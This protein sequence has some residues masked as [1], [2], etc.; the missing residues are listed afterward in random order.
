[1]KTR[2]YKKINVLLLTL[3]IACTGCKGENAELTTKEI[4]EEATISSDANS[5][6]N[7]SYVKDS[8][9]LFFNE[10]EDYKNYLSELAPS[11]DLLYDT[12]NH[13]N[14][15]D[16]KYKEV[17]TSIVDLFKKYNIAPEN[18]A[19]FYEN[20]RKLRV[21]TN[22]RIDKSE[23][24]G[25]AAFFESDA[26]EPSINIDE[27][28]V[29]FYT[30]LHEVIH[31][32]KEAQVRFGDKIIVIT[33][34]GINK[35]IIDEKNGIS[36]IE[37]YGLSFT[38]G[39]AEV[40][41]QRLYN[42]SKRL[43][44]AKY[45]YNISNSIIDFLMDTLDINLNSI[46]GYSIKD[47]ENAL[48]NIGIAEEDVRKI[49]LHMDILHT[50]GEDVETKDAARQ[51]FYA[52]YIPKLTK[53]Y[54]DL[55]LSTDMI[56]SKIGN[57]LKTSVIEKILD[58]N[59]IVYLGQYLQDQKSLFDEIDYLISET[60]TEH[61]MQPSSIYY[62]IGHEFEIYYELYGEASLTNGNYYLSHNWDETASNNAQILLYTENEE[63]KMC[64]YN[65]NVDG[66]LT[67][68]DYYGKIENIEN[69]MSLSALLSINAIKIENGYIKY[70]YPVEDMIKLL[71]DHKIT[72][73]FDQESFSLASDRYL[74]IQGS[75]GKII[76]VTSNQDGE[77]I[78]YQIFSSKMN[79]LPENVRIIAPLPELYEAEVIT[80]DNEYNINIKGDALNKYLTDKDKVKGKSYSLK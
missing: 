34:M 38:E 15:I 20:L 76:N 35:E 8:N 36:R 80:L 6:D 12:I 56:Y 66:S 37:Q 53:Y 70:T 10:Y 5:N 13:N 79:I 22:F 64:S 47:F 27:S 74:T 67:C 78:P 33:S 49:V 51:I 48:M 29:D 3:V 50:K 18:L 45:S 2:N 17:L 9:F 46:F 58:D 23:S 61:G 14:K 25:V 57:S 68:Y 54:L 24:T 71:K 16:G 65:E 32:C 7:I 63:I 11:Y 55:G 44:L 72:S 60:L 77:F 39:Q 26:D 43:Y 19:I 40:I 73:S 41:A 21:N 30:I 1:M 62:Y 59:K 69:G 28:F 4:T 31:S 42:S 75:G 52:N